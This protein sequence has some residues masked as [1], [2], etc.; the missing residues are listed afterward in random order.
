[1]KK[2]CILIV[3]LLFWGNS[4]LKAQD[5]TTSLGLRIGPYYGVTVKHFTQAKRA[6]EFILVSR[7]GGVG[8]TGL[9]EIHTPAFKLERLQAY[10]GIG[11]H[12]NVFNRFDDNFW[13]WDDDDRGRNGI[14]VGNDRRMNIG[15]DMILGL[16]YTL[17]DLPF[18]LSLDWKPAINIIGDYGLSSDQ[19]A[20]S[21]RFVF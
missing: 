3:V 11:G 17:K 7:R 5:Y 6:L 16:E 14:D 19:V 15:L 10:G 12:I 8:V 21:F 20:I 9:Y 4:A 2:V 13:D 1:M 18:N